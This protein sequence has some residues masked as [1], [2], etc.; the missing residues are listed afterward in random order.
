M[1]RFTYIILTAFFLS[2]YPN[3]RAQDSILYHFTFE[4]DNR[5]LLNEIAAK[6]SI[7]KV[8]NSTIYAY[9]NTKEFNE[10]LKY[11]LPHTL[12]DDNKASKAVSMAT[13]A[14]QMYNW[15]KYPTYEIYEELMIDYATKYNNICKLITIGTL[16]SGRKLLAVQITDNPSNISE[17]EPKVFYTST[18]HG[19]E[20]A[21]YVLLLRLIDY[22]LS[23]YNT[24][25]EVTHLINNTQI[26]INPLAN[27]NGTYY[28]GNST[29]NSARRYNAYNID[30]NRNFP[31][32]AVGNNP[33]GNAHQE[34][35]IY[36]MEFAKNNQFN[37]G[38]NIHGGSELVNYPWD[39]WSKLSADD[40]WWK[41]VGGNY[42]DS[43][44]ANSPDGY[45]TDVNNGLT[46]G[47]QWYRITGGRQD[48]MNYFH[49]TR[50]FT[51]EIS[52]IKLYPSSSLPNLWNYNKTALLSYLQESQ[53]GIHATVLNSKGK[54]VF[55][56]IEVINY[57]IDNSE[58]YSDSVTGYFTRYLKQGTY[59]LKVTAEGYAPYFL[60]DVKV[61]DGKKTQLNI[62]INESFNKLCLNTSAINKTF[63][64]LADYITINI[65]N[66]G[67]NSANLNLKFKET[68]AE[69]WFK[70]EVNDLILGANESHS[71]KINYHN[72][73][74]NDTSLNFN[75][76]ITSRDESYNIP[77][78]AK[79]IALNTLKITSNTLF[80]PIKNTNSFDSILITNLT[81]KIQNIN[82]N[83]ETSWLS[84][85]TKSEDIEAND[86]TWLKLNFNSSNLNTGFHK[87]HINI[88][89]TRYTI[90]TIVLNKP[91][92]ATISPAYNFNILKGTT[93]NKEIKIINT[94]NSSV[95]I[96]ATFKNTQPYF[97]LNYPETIH[98]TDT[99]IVSIE[100]TTDSLTPG[101]YTNEITINYTHDILKIPVSFNIETAPKLA[102]NTDTIKIKCYAGEKASTKIKIS[103][104]GG[105]S[106]NITLT[107][108]SNNSSKLLLLPNNIKNI[109]NIK[110]IE[111]PIIANAS[112]L[113][114]GNYI[115]FLMV[116]NIKIPVHIIVLTKPLLTIEPNAITTEISTNSIA[117]L[118]LN[119]S[120]TGDK[121][122]WFQM[123]KSINNSWLTLN[124]NTIVAK[125]HSTATVD[126]LINSNNLK[127]G[128]YSNKISIK[129]LTDIYN[130]PI[131]II[132]ND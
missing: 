103:N 32:P 76:I 88:N 50:E 15:D 73:P 108:E 63:N 6:I 123:T 91:K 129:T 57:D 89:N 100:I 1:N 75:L 68:Y 74:S 81:T 113:S 40:E 94:G 102:I 24:N 10:F 119:I 51:L 72:L 70:T 48:Y 85:Y 104:I 132:V 111:T 21:G 90:R 71:I 106:L 82:A 62:I 23:N 29:L 101:N 125:A 20:T 58:V 47:Y 109:I 60:H 61:L 27:P 114:Q 105:G 93:T 120:N 17:A 65:T 112:N 80:Y 16:N 30:L 28:G 95:D 127:P 35:T 83:S 52:G 56:K 115:R 67:N 53:N 18:M 25:P 44:Q 36:F 77:V 96:N 55:A 99:Q 116:N 42:R 49:V 11:N 13:S 79:L 4:I 87:G 78:K 37:L 26:F 121:D 117:T 22:L 3:I 130:I 98:A 39:T 69:D 43:A 64:T 122:S 97:K 7:D 66:C 86:S 8:D 46:N 2:F 84:I 128:Q 41:Y 126:F 5:A 14:E 59:N 107:E 118:Q 31:D 19:D 45:L 110:T 33:D 124:T 12:I 34:E 54:P 131:N 92:L 9:A 38:L